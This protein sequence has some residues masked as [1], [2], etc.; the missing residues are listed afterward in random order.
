MVQRYSAFVPSDLLTCVEYHPNV[1]DRLSLYHS[2]IGS[3]HPVIGLVFRIWVITPILHFTNVWYGKYISVSTNVSHDNTGIRY[4]VTRILNDQFL[5]DL[6]KYMVYSPLFLGTTFAVAY[7]L[8]F[9]TINTI[10]I[11]TYLFYVEEIW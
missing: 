3:K 5:F 11:H 8:T 7:G 4:N 1:D 9:A 6:T 2:R 10:R